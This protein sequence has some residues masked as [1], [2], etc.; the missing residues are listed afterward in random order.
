VK[1]DFIVAK[2]QHKTEWIIS[3]NTNRC[4]YADC[5]FLEN[6]GKCS[7]FFYDGLRR[8]H[9]ICAATRFRRQD[10]RETPDA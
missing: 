6:K 1:D 8:K 2:K 4:Q 3:S 7:A 5:G 9:I 10:I